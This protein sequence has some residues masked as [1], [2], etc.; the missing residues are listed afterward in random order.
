MRPAAARMNARKKTLVPPPEPKR[1][2]CQRCDETITGADAHIEARVNR[3][4]VVGG[5]YEYECRC[6]DTRACARRRRK[7]T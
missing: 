4:R 7:K 3:H 1:F 2:R 6:K 5:Q